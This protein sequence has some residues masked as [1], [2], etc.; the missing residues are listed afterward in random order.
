MVRREP[1]GC[2]GWHP[3]RPGARQTP[4]HCAFALTPPMFLSP[5]RILTEITDISD[6]RG[7]QEEALFPAQILAEFVVVGARWEASWLW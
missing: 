5:C 7:L 3:G 1:Y 4:V 6:P 2:P